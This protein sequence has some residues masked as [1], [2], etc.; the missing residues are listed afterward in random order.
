MMPFAG[1][2]LVAEVHLRDMFGNSIGEEMEL[3]NVKL[4]LF[5]GQAMDRS[6][7]PAEVNTSAATAR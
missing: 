5:Y 6:V 4:N 2:P 7:T 1:S 3:N